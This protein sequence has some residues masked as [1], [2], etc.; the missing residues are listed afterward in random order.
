MITLRKIAYCVGISIAVSVFVLFLYSAVPQMIQHNGWDK[1]DLIPINDEEMLEKFKGHPAYAAF[2]ERFPDAK[3]ELSYNKN[4][5]QGDLQVGIRNF[6][7][8]VELVL[9]LNY[10]G[11]NDDVNAHINCHVENLNELGID[12]SN[13][14]ANGLFVVDFIEY[15]E[16]MEIKTDEVGQ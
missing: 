15:T 7:T 6:E 4:Q 10:N 2:Y 12:R 5:N 13:M 1:F 14:R 9:Q 8:G 11:Y 3:E 16:C